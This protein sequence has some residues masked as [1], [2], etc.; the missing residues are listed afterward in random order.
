MCS[1]PSLQDDLA[2]VF[3]DMRSTLL[4]RTAAVEQVTEEICLATETFEQAVA[5]GSP[6]ALIV[7]APQ[8]C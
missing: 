4:V 7:S 2:L 1:I 6:G 8:V 3:V 5:Y